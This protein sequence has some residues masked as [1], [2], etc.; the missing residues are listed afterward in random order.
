MF[1]SGCCLRMAAGHQELGDTPKNVS[2]GDGDPSLTVKAVILS[3]AVV[4]TGEG[5]GT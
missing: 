2:G 5:R 1:M 4:N 3:A